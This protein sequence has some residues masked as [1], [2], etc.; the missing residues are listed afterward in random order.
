MQQSLHRFKVDGFKATQLLHC[1]TIKGFKAAHTFHRPK[2]KVLK[3]HLGF[4]SDT[5]ASLLQKDGF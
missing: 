1:F 4:Q 2:K 3:H 5:I